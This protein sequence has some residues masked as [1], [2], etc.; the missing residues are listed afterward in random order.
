[1][2]KVIQLL[3][4]KHYDELYNCL[5]KVKGSLEHKVFEA[6]YNPNIVFIPLRRMLSRKE[7]INHFK[8]YS[9]I[10]S[11][12]KRAISFLDLNFKAAGWL[13]RNIYPILRKEVTADLNNPLIKQFLELNPSIIEDLTQDANNS[14]YIEYAKDTQPKEFYP[15]KDPNIQIIK[16]ENSDNLYHA[17]PNCNGRRFPGIPVCLFCGDDSSVPSDNKEEKHHYLND[18]VRKIIKKQI[19]GNI[20]KSMLPSNEDIEQTLKELPKYI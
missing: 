7:A 5:T 17:C 2:E 15:T 12:L 3:I 1:M 4:S 6:T 20:K 14:N 16:P 19:S 13:K 8:K 10:F 9:K 18:T 11:N